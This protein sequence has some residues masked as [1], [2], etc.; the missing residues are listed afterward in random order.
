MKV[1]T[2]VTDRTE[3]KIYESESNLAPLHFKER[4][5]NPDGRLKER[6]LESD[7]P[8]VVSNASSGAHQNAYSSND[9]AM[10]HVLD[11]FVKRISQ[12]LREASLR[13]Q[14]ESLRIIADAQMLGKLR[15][16]FDKSVADKV[17]I[18]LSKNLI[19]ANEE[20]IR[21]SIDSAMSKA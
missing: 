19:Q 5:D 9:D 4:L 13:G 2:V 10:E 12:H 11:V 3:A 20:T 18:S 21:T 15:S 7:R 8:G 6:D 17:E 1:W 16:S 14:F